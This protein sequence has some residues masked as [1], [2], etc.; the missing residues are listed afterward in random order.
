MRKLVPTDPDEFQNGAISKDG[1]WLLYLSNESGRRELYVVPFPGPGEKRQ[2]SSSGATLGAWLG[3]HAIVYAQ[4]PDGKL[5]AVDVVAAGG[6]LSIGPPRPIFGGKVP[7]R[8]PMAVTSDGKRILI[9][10]PVEDNSSAQ[11]RLVSDWRAE[12]AKR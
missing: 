12:L 6:S 9:A 3:D 1:D 11:I 8:G 4:P 10:A 2:V 7:P 5:F